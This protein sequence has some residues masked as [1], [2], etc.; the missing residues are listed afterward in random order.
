MTKCNGCG[1]KL[2][3]TDPLKEGY[4]K[5]NSTL[6]NRCFRIVNYNEYL[7]VDV[8]NN[9]FIDIL[10]QINTT[11][12]LVVLVVDLLNI[13]RNLSIIKKY[14]NNKILFVFTKR[15]LIPL[16]VSDLK[17]LDYIDSLGINYCDKVIV[18]SKNN[19]NLDLLYEK[20]NKNKIDNDVYFIGFTNAGKSS[21]INKII[22]N[23]TDINCNITTSMLPSTT[24]NTIRINTK[25]FNIIDT[26]GILDEGNIINFIDKS[27][28]KKIIVKK[29]IKTITYQLKKNQYLMIEDLMIIKS[30]TD[31][32][33][34]LYMSNSLDIKRLYKEVRNN[35]LVTKNFE[36]EKNSDIVIPGLGFIKVASIS[37]LDISVIDGVDIFI[38][39]NLI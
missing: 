29:E 14:L 1:V 38:R 19:Y 33:L 6:C 24:L 32:N 39:N 27:M 7:S 13:P 21:L 11:N 3:Y 25:K 9:V 34:T 28:L 26:P 2:Q 22:Y 8:D 37:N 20:I 4:T 17:L 35:D 23:Y 31:S 30:N 5:E 15:D 16:S 10:K 18:S 12:S 36:I